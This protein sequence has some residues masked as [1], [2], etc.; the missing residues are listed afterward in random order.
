[1][2]LNSAPENARCA[3]NRSQFWLRFEP[4]HST[5][6]YSP[7]I[8]W[9][10]LWTFIKHICPSADLAQ[11]FGGNVAIDWHRDA[12]Y[13]HSQAYLLAL[14]QSTFEIE[15]TGGEVQSIDLT[16]GEFLQFDC[17][18]R[19]RATNVDPGR[20]GIEIWSAKIPLPC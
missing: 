14:G 16:G 18:L 5:K 13:G 7:A 17:K 20:I 9:H 11:V 8:D 10:R 2:E 6:L 3:K 12:S 4:N 1:L 15:L 19:H